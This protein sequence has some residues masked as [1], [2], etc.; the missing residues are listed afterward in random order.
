[1]KGEKMYLFSNMFSPKATRARHQVLRVENLIIIRLP[2]PYSLKE[3]D[4][5]K[6]RTLRLTF[7]K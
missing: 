3:Y 2:G 5:R 4:R 7:T 6:A 1:M